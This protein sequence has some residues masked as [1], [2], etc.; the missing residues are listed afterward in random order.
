MDTFFIG[1][2]LAAIRVRSF[3]NGTVPVQAHESALQCLTQRRPKGHRV[4]PHRH[5]PQKRTTSILQEALV[6]VSGKIR[7]SL[8]DAK[9]KLA[10]KFVV[11]KGEAVVLLGAAHAVDFLE[12]STLFEFK[13][14]PFLE[15]KRNV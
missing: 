9:G 12:T 4:L 13:N 11:Q 3:P 1:K 15:D 7:V 5:V 8:F 14:G 6:V 2:K 10:S